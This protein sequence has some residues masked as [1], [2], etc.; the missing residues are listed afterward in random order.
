MTVEKVLEEELPFSNSHKAIILVS[1]QLVPRLANA[2]LCFKLN[3]V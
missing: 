3:P 1:S 2:Q